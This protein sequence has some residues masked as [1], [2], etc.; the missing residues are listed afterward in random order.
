MPNRS[1]QKGDAFE[2]ELA[3]Y[4]NKAMNPCDTVEPGFH[5]KRAPLS[6]ASSLF[7]KNEPGPDLMGTPGLW[8]EAKRTET[9]RIHEAMAQACAFVKGD[10]IPVV[11]HRRNRQ[12]M[13]DALCY[14]RLKD[15]VKLYRKFLEIDFPEA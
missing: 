11:V 1:K 10:D 4:L 13:D 15:F 9:I 14:V 2:R 6:G 3:D 5:C 7:H 12:S 8:V